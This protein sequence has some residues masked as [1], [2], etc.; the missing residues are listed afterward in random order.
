MPCVGPYIDRDRL[1][2]PC[3]LRIGNSG[4]SVIRAFGHIAETMLDTIT[5]IV[6]NEMFKSLS[7]IK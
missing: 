2:Y 7:C 4:C 5:N 1:F 3:I 6:T